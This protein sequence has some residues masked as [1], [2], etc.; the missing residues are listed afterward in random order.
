[1]SLSVSPDALS[2]WGAVCVQEARRAELQELEILE[3]PV[4][5]RGVFAG[6]QGMAEYFCA[7]TEIWQPEG[8]QL[9]FFKSQ[10]LFRRACKY[11]QFV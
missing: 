5:V 8:K 2:P 11:S 3:L 7:E 10:A 9:Q 1:M 6:A 4:E